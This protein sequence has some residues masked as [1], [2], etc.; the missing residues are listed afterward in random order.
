M[1]DTQKYVLKKTRTS[2][3]QFFKRPETAYQGK[4]TD[5]ISFIC[6]EV[7]HMIKQYQVK[8]GKLNIEEHTLDLPVTLNQTIYGCIV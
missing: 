4:T 1:K 5:L 8:S 6:G 2:L 7:G 3:Q